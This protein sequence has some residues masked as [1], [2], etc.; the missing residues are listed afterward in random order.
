MPAAVVCGRKRSSYHLSDENNFA[1]S[2]SSSKKLRCSTS[3]SASPS[4]FHHLKS[5]FPHTPPQLLEKTLEEC[6]NDLDYA[7]KSLHEHEHCLEPVEYY[8]GSDQ[9]VEQVTLTDGDAAA[10]GSAPPPSNLPADGAEWVDLLVREMMSATSVDDARARAS[11]VLEVLEKSISAH[12]AEESA[13]SCQK[14]N[15]VVKE[16]IQVLIRENTILKKAVAIQ[17][18]R[19]KEFDD[20][21][22]ELQQLKQLVS[23]Y[24]EQLRTLEDTLE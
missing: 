14:E 11:R 3:A 21:N 12:A 16:K 4:G 15:M 2:S 1:Y 10:F 20:K 22:R 8:S 6:G 9:D 5:L 24:Q 13:E 19:Q 17:H 7:I 18:E 23:Q